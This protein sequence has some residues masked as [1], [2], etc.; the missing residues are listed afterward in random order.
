MVFFRVAS[1]WL[2]LSLICSTSLLLCSVDDGLDEKLYQ[3]YL[4]VENKSDVRLATLPKGYFKGLQK[5]LGSNFACKTIEKDGQIA[6]FISII[7]DGNQCIAYY[8]GIDYEVNKQLPIYF[9]L[10]QIVIEQ[11]VE[12]SLKSISFG[13]TALE[14]KANLG[15]LPVETFVWARHRISAVNFFVRKLFRNVPF[16]E[17]PERNALKQKK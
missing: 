5:S 3:L 10:L 11:A 16:D 17:A 8:V 2:N 15:A 1:A 7:K 14:P 9:R 12:W 13:R 6:G 4:N